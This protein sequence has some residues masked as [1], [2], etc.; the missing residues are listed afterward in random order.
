MSFVL[1]AFKKSQKERDTRTG[2][3][4]N[5]PT[6]ADSDTGAAKGG[7]P[8]TRRKRLIL[9]GGGMFLLVSFVAVWVFKPRLLPWGSNAPPSVVRQVVELTEGDLRS[10]APP[11][12]DVEPTVSA[13]GPE[14]SGAVAAPAPAA[15]PENIGSGEVFLP[16][17][18]RL[19]SLVPPSVADVVI[20]ETARAAFS[21]DA[22]GEVEDKEAVDSPPMLP[23]QLVDVRPVRKPPPQVVTAPPAAETASVSLPKAQDPLEQASA[24]ERAGR[25]D[26]AQGYYTK[27]IR[28]NPKSAIAYVGRGWSLLEL[29]KTDQAVGDFT[30][31]IKYAPDHP[32]G[33]LGRALAQERIGRLGGSAADYSKLA[34]LMPGNAEILLGRGVVGFQR[35]HFESAIAD[36]QSVADGDSQALAHYALLWEY[37]SRARAGRKDPARR[38]RQ[39]ARRV[40]LGPWPG[41][42]IRHFMGTAEEA[43]VFNGVA[44]ADA[45]ERKKRTCVVHFY[46]GQ[47]R[48][49]AGAADEAAEHFRK[50][51]ATDAKSYR[52]YWAAKAELGHL[53]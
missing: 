22:G 40:N 44:E 45:V 26:K 20:A 37:V 28:N 6:R 51:V 43:E 50:A 5:P 4:G 15:K 38:L 27:A 19:P 25:F 3:R 21:E 32:D 52:Q 35:Q 13:P 1:N 24:Y 41:A 49:A 17:V 42:L 34:N 30:R 2:G 12:P 46:L 53:Q 29:G 23:S 9:L 33:Y 16:D 36:F 47:V 7:K 14:H 39:R 18:M 8:A 11:P 31:A 10:A 48:L